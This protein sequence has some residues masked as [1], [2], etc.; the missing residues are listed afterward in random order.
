MGAVSSRIVCVTW[1]QGERQD[2]RLAGLISASG[3]SAPEW[4]PSQRPELG[5]PLAAA[6]TRSPPDGARSGG[7][8]RV[9]LLGIEPDGRGL[10]RRRRPGSAPRLALVGLGRQLPS[11]LFE[12]TPAHG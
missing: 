5:E 1:Y 12:P 6:R 8:L 4:L 2:P 11:S 7:R 10:L 9:S 3:P